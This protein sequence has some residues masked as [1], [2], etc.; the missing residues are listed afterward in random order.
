VFQDLARCKSHGYRDR[1]LESE[2]NFLP[3]LS[4]EASDRLKNIDFVSANEFVWVGWT[5][6]SP[7]SLGG[8]FWTWL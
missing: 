1:Q 4:A 6:S 2:S 3:I 7:S 8:D 5:C